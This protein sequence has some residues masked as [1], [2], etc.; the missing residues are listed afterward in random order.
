MLRPVPIKLFTPVINSTVFY[1]A[2]TRQF[3]F[4]HIF[5]SKAGAYPSGTLT[6]RATRL[7]NKYS[8]RMNF[9]HWDRA[10]LLHRC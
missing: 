4:S 6:Q 10:S 1:S 8:T 3:H 9:L 5:V 7:T 2:T